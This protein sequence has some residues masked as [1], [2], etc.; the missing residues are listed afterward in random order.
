MSFAPLTT[1]II[2]LLSSDGEFASKSV[3]SSKNRLDSVKDKWNLRLA[4]GAGTLLLTCSAL[5][6]TSVT[7][8]D[9]LLATHALLFG[10][11][12]SLLY[13]SSSLLVSCYFPH[14]HSKRSSIGSLL[15]NLINVVLIDIL[16]WR[17][18]LRVTAILLL[19]TGIYHL[20]FFNLP[21]R[22]SAASN[23]TEK[24]DLK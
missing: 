10:A 24:C 3:T 19:I 20:K 9:W 16:D 5:L 2:R 21:A 4:A 6:S 18:T 15:F 12:S 14:S 22:I 17:I 13:P 23:S 8:P 1:L 11:G 7:S